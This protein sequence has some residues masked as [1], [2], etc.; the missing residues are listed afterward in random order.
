MAG[1]R[2]KSHRARSSRARSNR[3]HE[4]PEQ[5]RA[6]VLGAFERWLDERVPA[7]RAQ[8]DVLYTVRTACEFKDGSLDS[9]NPSDWS[10]DLVD[11]I[12]GEVFPRKVVGVDPEY[13]AAIVPAMHVYLDFLAETGRWKTGNDLLATRRALDGLATEMPLRVGNP[14]YQG[15]GGRMMQMAIDQ[16]IDL[17]AEGAMDEVVERFNAMPESFRRGLT[18]GDGFDDFVEAV[19]IDE[20]ALFGDDDE[21][22]TPEQWAAL[23]IEIG[24]RGN[25]IDFNRPISVEIPAADVEASAMR[26]STLVAQARTLVD[27]VGGSR[28][29]TRDG[30]LR[31]QDVDDLLPRLGIPDSDWPAADPMWEI[32]AMV[33]PWVATTS[34]GMLVMKGRRVRQGRLSGIFESADEAETQVEIGRKA[35]HVAFDVLL[36]DAQLI[37]SEAPAHVLL[38]V[39]FT[40]ASCRPT[41]CNLANLLGFERNLGRTD[42]EA[43]ADEHDVMELCV[44]VLNQLRWLTRLG[45]MDETDGVARASVA[46]RPALVEALQALEAPFEV[47]LAV[48]AVPLLEAMPG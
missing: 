34:S 23:A 15:M 43:S 28:I 10:P 1:R 41:G 17:T 8:D 25:D 18:P 33:V 24:L 26:G 39:A 6:R 32:N 47:S 3:V 38:L 12:F 5:M 9:P 42:F 14:M 16:G 19:D 48:G 37:E 36:G 40:M 11:E 2:R 45:L 22:L 29:I 13:V 7:G 30:G 27:W 31:R 21:D 20:D 4:T 35:A 46:F 44:T